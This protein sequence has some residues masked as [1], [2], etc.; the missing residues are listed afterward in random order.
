MQLCHQ[1]QSSSKILETDTA[2]LEFSRKFLRFTAH[3]FVLTV[4]VFWSFESAVMPKSTLGKGKCTQVFQDF[5]RGLHLVW[6]EEKSNCFTSMPNFGP[7]MEYTCFVRI[8]MRKKLAWKMFY[9]TSFPARRLIQL[10]WLILCKYCRVCWHYLLSLECYM[11]HHGSGK[12]LC[13]F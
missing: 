3:T 11:I 8:Q 10:V 12:I 1:L 4:R 5:W 2:S 9:S 7:L 13:L 6:R